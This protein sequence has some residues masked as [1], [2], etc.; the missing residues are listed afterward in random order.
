MD[1]KE[2]LRVVAAAV[3]ADEARA[4]G[5]TCA[6]FRELRDRIPPK[7]AADVAA[8][9]PTRLRR[10]WDEDPGPP[11]SHRIH[12]EE[13]IG[14]VR[15]RAGLPDDVEATRAVNAVFAT[16]QR[17]LGSPTGTDGEAW[18]IFSVLP[19]DLKLVWLGARASAGY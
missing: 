14:R 5:V 6:V 11:T 2:F 8:Q 17:L 4:E 16:L 1:A 18:D 9:L 12:R 15:Q 10:L 3:G 7:E 19:K 13:F